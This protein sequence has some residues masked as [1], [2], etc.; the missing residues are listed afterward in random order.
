[1]SASE[2]TE[3]INAT[4]ALVP[5]YREGQHSRKRITWLVKDIFPR[6]TV[7]LIVGE[8]QA[9]KSF[10]AIDLA[11]AISEGRPFLGHETTQGGVLYIATEGGITIPGRLRA[12][13]QGSDFKET[14]VFVMDDPPADLMIASEVGRVIKTAQQ[15]SAEMLE[16]TG[17]P[18]AMIIIDTLM[19]ALDI[20]NWNDYGETAKGMD[21]LRRM[22]R[23][24][25]VTTIGVHHHGKDTSR[26]PAGSVA[27][28]AA[29]DCE[30][31]VYKTGQK[32]S[33]KDRFVI[34]TKSRFREPGRTRHFELASLPPDHREEDGDEEAFVRPL[35]DDLEVAD[36]AAP[37]PK[38]SRGESAFCV[39]AK[40]ALEQGI[41]VGTDDH[42]LVR[43]VALSQAKD[44]FLRN[45]PSKGGKDPDAAADRAWRRTLE[46]IGDSPYRKGSWDGQ[47]WLYI[48]VA[49]QDLAVS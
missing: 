41:E 33:V 46:R 39:A 42:G 48:D 23:E 47:E 17:R 34:L 32:G 13:R 19:F 35:L 27:I 2:K 20:K 45:Y 10:L 7:G 11:V 3:V 49:Q 44:I 28:T 14:P 31:S 37:K 12:A 18:L 15:I 21:V 29:A 30:L 6:D 25:G 16:T 24:V 4:P 1:M 9:G 5:F 36:R 8:S 40:T 38:T 43:A 26:G 22:S